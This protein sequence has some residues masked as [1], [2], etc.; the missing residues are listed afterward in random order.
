MEVGEQVNF[1][2]IDFVSISMVTFLWVQILLKALSQ[3]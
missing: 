2:V 1:L 3:Y